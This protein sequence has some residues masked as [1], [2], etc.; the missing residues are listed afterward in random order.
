MEELTEPIRR[1]VDR[2]E[3]TGMTEFF[4]RLSDLCGKADKP[5]VLII[6]EADSA[7]NNQVFIDLL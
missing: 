4:E 1:I 3:K 6:D 5:L 7:S 2:S